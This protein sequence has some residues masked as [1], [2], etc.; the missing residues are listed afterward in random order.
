[1]WHAWVTTNEFGIVIRLNYLATMNMSH[2]VWIGGV[3]MPSFPPQPSKPNTHKLGVFYV[4]FNSSS[5]LRFWLATILTKH[6]LRIYYL[7]IL[8]HKHRNQIHHL[9]L[10]YAPILPAETYTP[11]KCNKSQC[12]DMETTET[13][14]KYF[15]PHR[16]QSLQIEWLATMIRTTIAPV[17]TI[18]SMVMTYFMDIPIASYY[19]NG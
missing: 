19:S 17:C 1:M 14:H 9:T 18:A 16:R 12:W 5:V 11:V 15:E 8:F 6:K 7:P 3:M 13:S 4:Y 2:Q 10:K